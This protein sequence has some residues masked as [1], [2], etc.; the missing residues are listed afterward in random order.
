MEIFVLLLLLFLKSGDGISN[1]MRGSDID[2]RD[3]FSV[4]GN[5]EIRTHV[6]K[7]RIS[8]FGRLDISKQS[9]ISPEINHEVVFVVKQRNIEELKRIL[10]DVSDPSSTN[11]GKHKTR[12]EVADL[13]A[14]P[15]SRDYLV[16]YLT[17]KGVTVVSETLD[18]EY[19]TANAPIRLW[20]EMFHTEFFMFHKT[21]NANRM[22][23]FVRAEYYY[24]PILLDAHVESVFKTVQ[25]PVPVYG[26][27]SRGSM[28][29]PEMYV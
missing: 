7:Q 21:S 14:N 3:L 15:I 18:G 9:H 24:L 4:D 22:E 29:T 2:N 26:G 10:H 8:G 5:K 6:F 16:S 12:R 19:V 20:E 11:Y 17:S 13:T 27:P 25:M 28:L 23:K 1:Y